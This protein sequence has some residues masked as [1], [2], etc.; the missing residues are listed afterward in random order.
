MKIQ[1]SFDSKKIQGYFKRLTGLFSA[2]FAKNVHQT[3]SKFGEIII[4][5]RLYVSLQEKQYD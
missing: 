3:S 1:N 5:K 4:R 2:L